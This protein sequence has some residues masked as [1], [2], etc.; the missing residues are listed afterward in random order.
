MYYILCRY[1]II[2]CSGTIYRR[3]GILIVEIYVGVCLLHVDRHYNISRIITMIHSGF[4]ISQTITGHPNIL[5]FI[6]PILQYC[7]QSIHNMS[8]EDTYICLYNR[9]S[10]LKLWP[11][12]SIRFKS[13]IIYHI[14]IYIICIHIICTWVYYNVILIR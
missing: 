14:Y 2:L 9:N 4:T 1:T 5:N 8:G 7:L 10:G 6:H 12:I 13:E 11:Q 3:I